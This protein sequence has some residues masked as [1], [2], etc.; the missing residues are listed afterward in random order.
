[1]RYRFLLGLLI[2]GAAATLSFLHAGPVELALLRG[3]V[4]VSSGLV[5]LPLIACGV[6]IG[7]IL[8]DELGSDRR[9]RDRAEG[10]D[11]T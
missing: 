9:T 3:S 4:E 6:V 11:P 7:W 8:H 5:H 10:T 1:M 2:G